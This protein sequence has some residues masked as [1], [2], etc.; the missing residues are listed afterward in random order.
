MPRGESRPRTLRFLATEQLIF[1]GLTWRALEYMSQMYK[2]DSTLSNSALQMSLLTMIGCPWARTCSIRQEEGWGI[3]L[4]LSCL[5]CSRM[6]P[7][8]LSWALGQCLQQQDR[9]TPMLP[10][11]QSST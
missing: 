8:H 7:A 6:L 9:G 10:S 11:T 2:G 5:Q 3:Q 1:L 4:L